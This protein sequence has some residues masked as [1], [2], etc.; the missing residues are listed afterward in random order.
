M[1]DEQHVWAG[2]VP[3]RHWIAGS[4]GRGAIPP[5][6]G[7][8]QKSSPKPDDQGG[9]TSAEAE[10]EADAENDATG[11]GPGPFVTD[12]CGAHLDCGP[13]PTSSGAGPLDE[14]SLS[15][16]ELTG[17]GW[18]ECE[19]DL[20]AAAW[21]YLQQH[22]DLVA[23]AL[24][25]ARADDGVTECVLDYL[26]NQH[27]GT[28][29]VR[30]A[31]ATPGCVG[32]KMSGLNAFNR[33]TICAEGEFWSTAVDLF[34]GG[35]VNV[36]EQECAALA[37]AA[38]FL[39]ELGHVCGSGRHHL[40]DTAATQFEYCDVSYLL[41]GYFAVEAFAQNV[42][43]AGSPCCGD[44]PGLTPGAGSLPGFVGG[45]TIDDDAMPYG[46]P[47]GMVGQPGNDPGDCI[48]CY[49]FPVP[50]ITIVS[51]E[52]PGDDVDDTTVILDGA[53]IR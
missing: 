42:G 38:S 39:H 13:A 12:H 34:C 31:G 27:R 8:T 44:Y 21:G 40:S 36:A 20:L 2:Y 48:D 35:A 17:G 28:L 24:C 1:T 7:A 33:I 50:P 30:R 52:L 4:T 19:E 53:V 32:A 43:A 49:W 16:L 47:G 15:S 22:V 18:S 5:D 26:T 25:N 11:A 14:P 41:G 46:G 51:H 9:P 29:G 10:A 3:I 37:V 45:C 23:W 6:H